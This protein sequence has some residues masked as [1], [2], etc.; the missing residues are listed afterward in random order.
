MLS[1]SPASKFS[2][3][4]KSIGPMQAV[5][6]VLDAALCAGIVRQSLE[7]EWMGR[8]GWG[9]ELGSP[10]V[11]ADLGM[12]LDLLHHPQY[13]PVLPCFSNL[14]ARNANNTNSCDV[15]D[16]AGRS[17]AQPQPTAGMLG[18]A[19]PANTDLNVKMV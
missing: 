2:L 18:R 19:R 14:A 12:A 1:A 3:D 15:D 6:L 10:N 11:R 13:V 9:P 16:H 7:R 17:D 5:V 4:C 8:R